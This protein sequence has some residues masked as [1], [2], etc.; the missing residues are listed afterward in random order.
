MSDPLVPK[1]SVRFQG[2]VLPPGL[3][4]TT[5]KHPT[6]KVRDQDLDYDMYLDVII[7]DGKIIVDCSVENYRREKHY[8]RLF[9]RAFD[10]ANASVNLAAFSMGAGASVFFDSSIEDDGTGQILVLRDRELEALCTSF[11]P[12]N[13]SFDAMLIMFSKICAFPALFAISLIQFPVH[14]SFQQ[15]AREQSKHCARLSFQRE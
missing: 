5:R 15:T 1:P 13:E 11:S 9:M 7:E 12:N 8:S 6:V 14:T 2:R 10:I 4:L 3:N